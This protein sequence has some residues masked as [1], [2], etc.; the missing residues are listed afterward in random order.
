MGHFCPP[1]S[2]FRIRLRTHWPDWIRIQSGFETLP[3]ITCFCLLERAGAE[4][5]RSAPGPVVADGGAAPAPGGERCLPRPQPTEL[6]LPA[7]RRLQAQRRSRLPVLSRG[8]PD[9][10]LASVTERLRAQA[11]GHS[12][13]SGF[14]SAIISYGSGSTGIR[15]CKLRIRILLDIFMAILKL[16][17]H[18]Y[19]YFGFPHILI[20][21][22]VKLSERNK[23]IYIFNFSVR[24]VSFR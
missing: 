11:G 6:A 16:W 8:A 14:G 17:N 12:S 4:P 22:D 9:P 13:S 18:R 24:S 20:G 23:K 15:K 21:A 7:A 5:A 10:W 3:A 2:W 1:G 19:L